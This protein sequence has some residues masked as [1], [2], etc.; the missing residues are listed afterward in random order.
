MLYLCFTVQVSAQYFKLEG[1]CTGPDGIHEL[2]KTQ[3]SNGSVV[4]LG[5]KGQDGSFSINHDGVYDLTLIRLS[6]DSI[7]WTGKVGKDGYFSIMAQSDDYVLCAYQAYNRNMYSDT[8]YHEA[9]IP[10]KLISDTD[11]GQISLSKFYCDTLYFYV[12]D[13]YS[14]GH[15]SLDKGFSYIRQQGFKRNRFLPSVEKYDLKTIFT[16]RHFART[17]YRIDNKVNYVP[18]LIVD[19]KPVKMNFIER[20]NLLKDLSA[21]DMLYFEELPPS[22]EFPGGVIRLVTPAYHESAPLPEGFFRI[23]GRLDVRSPFDFWFAFIQGNRAGCHSNR[24]GFEFQDFEIDIEKGDYMLAVSYGV[25]AFRSAFYLPVNLYS[26]I[27]LGDIT[28]DSVSLELLRS[29]LRRFEIPVFAPIP[30]GFY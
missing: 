2:T 10:V 18:Q 24:N 20:M 19:D 23:R 30:T 21:K 22:E 6:D 17:N 15:G 5:K 1:N 9:I 7:V 11:L 13:V 29:F 28:P 8:V 25:G 4:W 26:D 14:T 3:L 27:N 12:S 16:I